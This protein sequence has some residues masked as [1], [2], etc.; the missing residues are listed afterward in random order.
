MKAI[1]GFSNR[2]PLTL[3]MVVL[4]ITV[5]FLV[6]LATD[7]YVSRNIEGSFEEFLEEVL[8]KQSLDDRLR[9]D[10]YM[11][12]F[13]QVAELT[14]FQKALTDYLDS[15]NWFEGCSDTPLVNNH[16]PIW[17]LDHSSLRALA[18]PR[19]AILFNPLGKA[20]E[21]FNRETSKPLPEELLHPSSIL[22]NKSH[23]QTHFA[24]I[25]RS[26]YLIT[27]ASINGSS[28]KEITL[29]L[30]SP[31]DDELLAASQGIFSRNLVGLISED[32]KTLLASSKPDLLPSGT[33]LEKV[34][35][36]YTVTG[37]TYHD[38]G[39]AEIVVRITSF[40]SR[41]KMKEMTAGF[42]ALEK[43]GHLIASIVYIISFTLVML[44][45]T[46][47]I[48]SLTERVGEFS[49]KV[50]GGSAAAL[51][52][53]DKLYILEEKF[54][55]LTDEILESHQIIERSAEEK[56]AKQVELR[57][58]GKQLMLLESVMNI[59]GIGIMVG[60]KGEY[61]SA[62]E[63][64]NDFEI[65]VGKLSKFHVER[66][67]T[68]ECE[69]IDENN[70]KRT[71]RLSSAEIFHDEEVVLVHDITKERKVEAEKEGLQKELLQTQKIE[72]IGRLAGGVAHDFNN[73]LSVI[74]GYAELSLAKMQ[75]D[76]ILRNNILRIN[77]SAKKAANLTRQL[78]AFSRKQIIRPKP[79]DLNEIVDAVEK[80]LQR[81]IGEDIEIIVC[82]GNGL[83]NIKADQTQ[84][85]QV[86]V[87]LAVN[88]RDAMP[89][90]GKFVI[91]TE[92]IVVD[93]SYIMRHE[94]IATGEYV[95]LMVSDNGA[96]I[97]DSDISMI[98]EP[99]YTTKE[100]GKGTGL[101]LAT[102][103]GIIKQNSGHIFVYSEIGIGSTFKV[104][105]PRIF[106]TKKVNEVIPQFDELKRGTETILLVEDEQ[107]VR[108]LAV[109]IL[110][111]LGYLV[112][113][114]ENGAKAEEIFKSYHGKIDLLLTDVIMP[115]K[116]GFELAQIIGDYHPGIKVLYMTGYTENAIVHQ[117][118][119]NEGVNLVQKPLSPIILANAVRGVL[120]T[121]K[122]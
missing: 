15:K 70:E 104:Y 72:S 52:G 93:E 87:N 32:G 3:K 91:E 101:G 64:M 106:E 46:S 86:L 59:L 68:D 30:A 63:I 25:G 35:K 28:G 49:R 54:Q 107:T 119:V 48:G 41:R 120:D 84:I 112:I 69:I 55:Q 9:F 65:S 34:K 81:L 10:N 97:S 8:A 19:Y 116:G 74:I 11:M 2:L 29:L 102:V 6:G 95:R 4:T 31:V 88:A 17:F 58:Q 103:Y 62:N 42:I 45:I 121:K 26:P 118:V 80:M 60:Y 18:V 53:G 37:R 21:V 47:R 89:N 39:G 77:E 110:S 115:K 108:K 23:D 92:N 40:V 98:F 105:L 109:S 7:Q 73:I 113:E 99:F 27:T 57:Q 14:V 75:K 33:A 71:F 85:E 43:R 111:G 94:G 16:M 50:L 67:M 44:W 51:P 76:D 78:L 114:A 66:G 122:A 82:K 90:G 12:A 24:M 22:L 13:H 56:V 20:C 83:W 36:N 96:G 61:W 5:T 117:G 100:L 79:L 1:Q 38:Y